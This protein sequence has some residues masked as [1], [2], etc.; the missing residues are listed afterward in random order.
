MSAASAADLVARARPGPRGDELADGGPARRPA[1]RPRRPAAAPAGPRRRPL[2]P[3]QQG[4]APAGRPGAV[5]GQQHLGRAEEPG[6]AAG[7]GR[8]AP[9]AG[10]GERHAPPRPASR[11]R[12]RERWPMARRVALGLGSAAARPPRAAGGRL[13]AVARPAARSSGTARS[14]S[15]SVPVLSRQITSTRA[16]VSTAGSSW[17][18]TWRRPRRTTP[19][20]KATLV[21]STSPSGTMATIPA[22]A[23][24]TASRTAVLQA[25]LADEQQDRRR[26]HRP[27]DVLEDLVDAGPQLRAGQGEPAA[28]PRRAGPR[29]PP[30]RPWSPGSGRSRRP[31]SCPT[32]AGR[33]ALRRPARTRR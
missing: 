26:D 22:T 24:L 19:T 20:A 3:A 15:V 17:T 7:E 23:P 31:R 10:R 33:R 30:G 25:Q 29:R 18:S 27:G 32:A 1:A 16:R 14:P 4:A 28:P 21:S 6:A 11:R 12:C 8:A 5:G 2:G 9:L 13:V